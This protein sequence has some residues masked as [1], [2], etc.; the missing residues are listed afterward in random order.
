MILTRSELLDAGTCRS[1]RDRD[2]LVISPP[3]PQPSVSAVEVRE[4]NRKYW[5]PSQELER[6]ENLDRMVQK[7]NLMTTMPFTINIYSYIAVLNN[8]AILYN[9]FYVI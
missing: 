2:H 8:T 3:A 9:L 7:I 6:V 1:D 4:S 5:S